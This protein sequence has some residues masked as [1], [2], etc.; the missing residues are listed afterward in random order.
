MISAFV[1]VEYLVN[2]Q[3]ARCN[4]KG[5]MFILYKE[6]ARCNFGSIVY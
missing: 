5:Y 6:P 1:G 2:L 3:N 4:N